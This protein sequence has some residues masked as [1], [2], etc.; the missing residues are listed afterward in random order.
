MYLAELTMRLTEG[1][2]RLQPE[3]RQQ[4]ASFLKTQQREDGGFPGRKGPSDLYYTGFA[5]RALA[6]L[7][8]LDRET[9]NRAEIGRAHV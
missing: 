7:D 2:S 3:V 9:A 5:L 6:L 1:V 4:Q 8:A